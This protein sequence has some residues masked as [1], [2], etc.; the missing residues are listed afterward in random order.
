MTSTKN[1][2]LNLNIIYILAVVFFL[3]L[4]FLEKNNLD[5]LYLGLL[6][7]YY[8]RIKKYRSSS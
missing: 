1:T 3:V 7:F 6:T 8:I 5:I 4:A 2:I